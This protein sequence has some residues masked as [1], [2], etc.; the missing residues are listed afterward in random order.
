MI[1]LICFPHY[2]CGGLLSDILTDN[3]SP[4]NPKTMG[5][6]SFEHSIAKIGDTESVFENFSEQEFLRNLNEKNL[7]SGSYVGTHCWP[8][9]IDISNFNNVIC[10]TTMTYK[11][12]IYRWARSFYHYYQPSDPWQLDSQ[13]DLIDKQRETAKNY[14]KPFR[15]V[16][17]ATNIEFSEIVECSKQF[18]NLVRPH[19]FL[20]SFE[21]WKKINEFLYSENFW[22]STPVR[23][24]YEAELELLTGQYYVY[25]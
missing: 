23:R 24:Y 7:Q 15:P 1:N 4:I 8:G 5:I 25:E 20:Q 16:A 17:G 14:L 6:Q 9:N 21:R 11:S 18:Q 19:N 13:I 2:T 10:V 3:M 22:E 12:R